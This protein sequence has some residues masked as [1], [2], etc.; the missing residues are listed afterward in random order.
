MKRIN[1]L[2][3]FLLIVPFSVSGSIKTSYGR[4]WTTPK[5]SIMG[6]AQFI[7]NDYVQK[8]LNNIYLKKFNVN[9]NSEYSLHN[10]QYMTN[11]V[12]PR[13]DAEI[14][15]DGY[16][17]GKLLNINFTFTIPIYN[18][19]PN[20]TKENIDWYKMETM[21][22]EEL[23]KPLFEKE[24]DAEGFPETYKKYL[25]TIHDEFPNWKFKS[26]KTGL[27]FPTV[28]RTQNS[29][30]RSAISTSNNNARCSY[31]LVYIETNKS[32]CRPLDDYLRFYLDPRN[33]L[34]KRWIFMFEDLSYTSKHTESLIANVLKGTHMSGMSVPDQQSFKSIFVEAGKKHKISSLY[35]ATFAILEGGANGSTSTTGEKF[36]Y[37]GKDYIGIYNF[38]NIGATSSGRPPVL[39]GLVFASGGLTAD[40]MSGTYKAAGDMK[41]T[42]TSSYVTG[43]KP[44]VTSKNYDK[45]NNDYVSYVANASGKKNGANSK[46]KTGDVLYIK[47][48]SK[49]YKYNIVITGD[50][51][52][53]GSINSADILA[54]RQHLL[55]QNKLSDAKLKAADINNDGRINSADLLALRLHLLG[56]N[57]IRQ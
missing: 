36:T 31:P 1:Y 7:S 20:S 5:K 57:T 13:S 56:K 46:V 33:F 9:P 40:M 41:L 39:K 19:M 54:I 25:R 42:L 10:H 6:G 4:P 43:F 14:A 35:L 21:T 51:T 26:L 45:N 24:L 30:G 3:L 47:A 16:R 44:G 34:D 52:G 32:W 28:V 27:S 29:G 12:A 23:N 55:N 17:A 22:K 50:I 18:N 2:F 38:Y 53:K 8:G 48:E 11:I 49:T 37:D 15:Y